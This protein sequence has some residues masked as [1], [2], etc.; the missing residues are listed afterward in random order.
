MR[1][2]IVA[3]PYARRR[4]G[5]EYHARY[6]C[7]ALQS[8]G[9]EVR[10][11]DPRQ[12]NELL[13]F[14]PD[15]TLVEGVRR[16]LLLRLEL[17]TPSSLTRRAIFTHGSFYEF[18]HRTRLH[19]EG[20]T[21]NP[22]LYLAKAAFDR[23]IMRRILR[24][25]RAVFTLDPRESSDLR[26]LFGLEP[27]RIFPIPNFRLDTINRTE[28][29]NGESPRERPYVCAIGRIEPRKNFASVVSAI[30]GLPI[31]FKLAGRDEGGLN[32]I[33]HRA[34]T[35]EVTNFEYVGEVSE[36]EKR[37]LIRGSIGTV[38]PSYFEGAPFSVIESISLGRPA[39]C[40]RNS[41]IAH[42]AVVLADTTPASLRTAILHLMSQRLSVS[43]RDF[44]SLH[45]TALSILK[46]LSV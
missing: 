41:Y 36:S 31:G 29:S 32:A 24:G 7:A 3:V 44:P 8:L 9:T 23:A 13:T 17:S 1:V 37:A 34:E 43:D 45:E 10:L 5:I 21:S 16:G 25:Y 39:I 12:V 26:R 40:T 11:F 20:H 27:G 30:K 46:I 19:K 35:E 28:E 4:G 18:A 22:L 15:W 2:A 14:Q 6:L 42:P 33:I 38:L